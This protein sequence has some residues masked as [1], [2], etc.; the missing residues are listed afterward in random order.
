M[1]FAG[2]EKANQG[3]CL[4]HQVRLVNLATF[5]GE[6]SAYRLKNNSLRYLPH[7]LPQ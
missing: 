7:R 1:G 3:I 5:D 4:R 2:Q 6:H